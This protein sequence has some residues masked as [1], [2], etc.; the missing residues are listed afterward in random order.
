MVGLPD[1]AVKESLH[2]VES[3]IHSAGFRM[4][5]QKIVVNLAPAD[6]RKEGSAYDVAIA[7][8]ILAAGGRCRRPRGHGPRAGAGRQGVGPG[9]RPP[10]RG[11]RS[12]PAAVGASLWIPQCRHHLPH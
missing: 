7:I 1:N 5:R 3:A 6:L 4:P 9:R 12:G 10:P 8:G 11:Q 2:R